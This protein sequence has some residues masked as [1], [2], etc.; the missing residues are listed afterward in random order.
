[1]GINSSV[2]DRCSY[3]MPSRVCV[4]KDAGTELAGKHDFSSC[5]DSWLHGRAVVKS[6]KFFDRRI[7]QVGTDANGKPIFRLAPE[8]KCDMRTKLVGDGC[9]VCNPELAK[10]M[11]KS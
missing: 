5:S 11:R 6:V 9:A 3:R 1:M 2:P 4:R 10:E 8:C 7:E